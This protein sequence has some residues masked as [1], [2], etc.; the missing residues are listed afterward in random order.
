MAA[1]I[2]EATTGKVRML[3]GRANHV[4][5]CAA[6]ATELGAQRVLCPATRA[7]HRR[8]DTSVKRG[9]RDRRAHSTLFERFAGPGSL[10]ELYLA[11]WRRLRREPHHREIA[12][13]RTRPFANSPCP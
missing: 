9:V 11:Q 10:I 13:R 12:E 8:D 1:V 4:Q 7:L 2:A 3:A 5:P 6:S